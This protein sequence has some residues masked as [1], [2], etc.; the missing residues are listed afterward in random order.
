LV[1]FVFNKAYRTQQYSHKYD[2]SIIIGNVIDDFLFLINVGLMP[3]SF[4]FGQILAP[5]L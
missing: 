3:Y 2:I 1:L 5:S 4:V